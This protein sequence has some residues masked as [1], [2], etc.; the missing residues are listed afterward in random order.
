M[1]RSLRHFMSWARKYNGEKFTVLNMRKHFAWYL[2]GKDNC[3]ELRNAINKEENFENLIPI[4]ED[5]F[6]E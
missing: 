3:A 2:K 6:K 4:I 1:K 5:A